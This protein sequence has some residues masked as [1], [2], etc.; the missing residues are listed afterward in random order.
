MKKICLYSERW[1]DGGIENFLVNIVVILSQKN[2]FSIATSQKETNAYDKIL[3]NNNCELISM[4]DKQIKNPFTRTFYSILNLKKTMSDGNYDVIHINMYNSIGLFYAFLIKNKKN[5][6]I[7]HAHNTGIDND[8]FYIK[9][10]IHNVLKYIFTNKNYTYIACSNEAA[11]F[12]FNMKKVSKVT[13]VNN[14][15]D[16]EKFIYNEETR[17]RMRKDLKLDDNTIVIGHVGRFVEQKNHSFLIDIFQEYN[18]INPNSKLLLIGTGETKVEIE[19]K[20]KKM[21]LEKNVLFVGNVNNVNEYMQAFDMLIL[22]SLYEGLGIVLIEAQ[23]SGLKCIVSNKIPKNAKITE[24]F[25]VANL[26]D[27]AR[28]WA[29]IIEKNVKYKR[30]NTT[31]EIRKMKYDRKSNL[32][33]MEGLYE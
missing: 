17:K 14:G 8:M 2:D 7:C 30:K 16:I 6:I 4:N 15:I 12:C 33:I 20:I 32:E 25:V 23:A 9:R 5:K 13:I 18:N 19:N 3:N 31:N 21:K 28:K 22:P 29:E 1:M 27:N 24:N 11:K 10:I 26:T